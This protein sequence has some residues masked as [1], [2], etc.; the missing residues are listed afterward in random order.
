MRDT[1]F[2]R[3][4]SLLAIGAEVTIKR[5]MGSFM[6][7]NNVSRPAVFRAGGIGITPFLRMLSYAAVNKLH[8][9]ISLFYAKRYLEDAAFMDPLRELESSTENFRFV[10][11]FTRRTTL[12]GD[13]R[14]RLAAS[15]RKCFPGM[16]LTCKA[17]SAT[18]P[19]HQPWSRRR[20]CRSVRQVSM[21][22]ISGRKSFQAINESQKCIW[23]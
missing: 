10:A 7:H 12:T 4:L 17:Q 11:T 20:A 2:K 22:T 9:T 13:G 23:S 8:P 19:G 6:L 15:A 14:A 21:K 5:P 1:A 16:Y 3:A 18:S